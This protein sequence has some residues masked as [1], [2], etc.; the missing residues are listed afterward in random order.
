MTGCGAAATARLGAVEIL[1]FPDAQ[2]WEAW[3]AENHGEQSE[4]WLR[5][6]KK[7]AQP[8][9]LR[10]G[11][12]LEVALCFGWIDGHRKGYDDVSFLQRY[13]RRSR[14]SSWSAINAAKAERL[15][16][17]GR[18][19]PAGLAEMQ[20]ARADGRWEAAYESQRTAEVP[21]D[22]AAALRS[23]AQVSAAFESLGRTERY[24]IILKLLKAR[25]PRVPRPR[26]RQ[27]GSGSA[28][29]L[30]RGRK[31][32]RFHGWAKAAEPA[33]P[34]PGPSG[35]GAPAVREQ[36]GRTGPRGGVLRAA[37]WSGFV[38]NRTGAGWRG[39][40]RLATLRWDRW[41]APWRRTPGRTGA[42]TPWAR[43]PCQ[44]CVST[45]SPL[46]SGSA[47]ILGALPPTG[48]RR[49]ARCYHRETALGRDGTDVPA[50]RG[51]AR[52]AVPFS[53]D[54]TFP[55]DAFIVADHEP[56]RPTCDQRT[57]RR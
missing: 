8:Q 56:G 32:S 47:H 3:L 44:D 29:R 40:E 17:A 11:D 35:S 28:R 26:S 20:A 6:G 45:A 39:S 38:T 9:R 31:R 42:R 43:C 50:N 48:E 46:E 21:E 37:I 23:D 33:Q 4:A 51:H 12:A 27:S 24:A 16:A 36:P 19:R 25:T 55:A 10:I 14:R 30:K 53:R 57:H 49:Y 34:P 41:T 1:D 15:V 54:D 2:H 13:S 7:G 5:I 52:R 22:L 18:M